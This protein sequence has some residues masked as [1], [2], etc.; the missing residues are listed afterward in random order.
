MGKALGMTTVAEGVETTE[1]ATFLR[2]RGCDEMQGFLFSK[3]VP[4]EKVPGLLE[5]RLAISPPL[6][7]GLQSGLASPG[8]L[9]A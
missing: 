3:P 7:P 4:P 9:I 1:Q 8:R 5:Q 6:Q 2:D